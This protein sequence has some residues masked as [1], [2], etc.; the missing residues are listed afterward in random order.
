MI[1]ND[2]N[3][4]LAGKGRTLICHS[5]VLNLGDNP[6]VAGGSYTDGAAKM[7]KKRKARQYK[8]LHDRV[9]LLMLKCVPLNHQAELQSHFKEQMTSPE[10][11][12]DECLVATPI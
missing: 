7:P 5:S 6:R 10:T 2:D 12:Y 8:P 9:L 1:C 11:E 3:Y 4:E